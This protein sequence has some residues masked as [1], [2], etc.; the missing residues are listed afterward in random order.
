MLTCQNLTVEMGL[1]GC[2]KRR[3]EITMQHQVRTQ[4]RADFKYFAHFVF[5]FGLAYFFIHSVTY[6]TLDTS[7]TDH[8]LQHIL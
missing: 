6:V 7:I 3:Y 4:T 1:T 5:W 8:N 2:P